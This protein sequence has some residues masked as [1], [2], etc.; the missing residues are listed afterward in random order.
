MA[1]ISHAGITVT[2]L[3][4]SE[5]PIAFCRQP[6]VAM[7]GRT[8]TGPVNDP[9]TVTSLQQFARVFGGDWPDSWLPDAVRQFFAAGG[10]QLVIVRI[11]NRARAAE[12]T[13]P[14]AYGGLTLRS[15]YP[16]SDE[17]LRADID[18]PH[19]GHVFH[20]TLQ[21]AVGG[22]IVDQEFYRDLSLDETDENFVT[23]E[24]A[25]SSLAEVGTRAAADGNA[26]IKPATGRIVVV[27]QPGTDGAALTDY[28]LIG[29]PTEAT[30]LFSLDPLPQLDFVYAPP[31]R[32]VDDNRAVF[33]A[34]AAKYT[35]QRRALLV[36]DPAPRTRQPQIDRPNGR[37][38]LIQYWPPVVERR[39]RA[40][41]VPIGGAILGALV[42]F[43]REGYGDFG[44]H[45]DETRIGRRYVPDPRASMRSLPVLADAGVFVLAPRRDQTLG[46]HPANLYVPEIERRCSMHSLRLL[47]LIERA[48]SESTRW[49]VLRHAEPAAWLELATQVSAFLARLERAGLIVEPYR[50]RCDAHTNVASRLEPGTVSFLVRVQP[51]QFNEAITLAVTQTPDGTRMTR[52][53]FSDA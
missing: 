2:E 4:G 11:T 32:Y 29:T 19:G 39:D 38:P 40:Q 13:L 3:G 33:R 27:S 26:T 9:V 46:V 14:A 47:L 34:A 20:L 16:G 35:E 28:D 17:T 51:R 43:Q 24:L 52:A 30:G 18:A 53:A 36:I 45:A 5:S 15:R 21:R 50:V 12:V 6:V 48:I 49:I 8:Q 37:L 25:T 42:R 1:A 7:L 41:R 44:F 10:S 31:S 23:A 22:R